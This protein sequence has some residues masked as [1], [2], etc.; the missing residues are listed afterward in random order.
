MGRRPLAGSGLSARKPLALR[1]ERSFEPKRQ[2]EKR[3]LAR[4]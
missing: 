3:A 1:N 4:L 2:G